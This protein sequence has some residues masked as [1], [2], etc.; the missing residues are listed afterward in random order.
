[1]DASVLSLILYVY[2]AMVT[3]RRS[4]SRR[5]P[6]SRRRRRPRHRVRRDRA[7]AARIRRRSFDT[8]GALLGLG[9]SLT[10]TTYIL[11]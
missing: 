9:A 4:S 6:A 5:E 8:V 1:M 10:Y 11:T 7:G 3:G 2:P